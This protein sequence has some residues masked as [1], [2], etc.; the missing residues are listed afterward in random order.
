MAMVLDAFA[1]Y[2]GDYLKQ[3]VQDEL[4]TMLG[5]SSEIDKLGDKLLDLKNFLTDADRRNITDDTVKVWVGQLKR[6]MY[7]A[8]DILDLCQLKAMEKRGSSSSDAGCYNPFLFCM[9]NPFH[10]RE[11]GTRIKALSQRLD[12]IKQRSAAFNFIN[13]GSYEEHS[14]SR[15]GN[16][17]RETSGEL[18]RS[19]VVGDKIEE[20][21]R[22]LVARITRTGNEASNNIM[23]VAIVGVGGIGKT[24]L[25]QKVFNDEALQ[26]D[27]SKKI[28][29]SVNQNFSEVELLRRAII[30]VRGDTQP[31]GNAK[32]TLQ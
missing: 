27:F 31:V 12:S 2:I 11:I 19:G 16:P 14:S 9:R 20:D 1:S 3:V 23:V 4:G 22:A 5:V 10:A 15:H 25:A 30:E 26:G 17:S 29:L 24:T 8:A 18:D 6:A 32:A 7:E 13:L 21:T 28:W